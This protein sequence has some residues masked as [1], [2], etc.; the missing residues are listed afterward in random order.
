MRAFAVIALLL[1]FPACGGGKGS[2]SS[3]GLSPSVALVNN[4][5]LLSWNASAGLADGYLIEQSTDNATWTQIQSVTETS[6]Y[7]DGLS[8]GTRYYFRVRS[9]NSA[10]N[11]PYSGSTSITL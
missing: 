9:F 8:V 2:N 3:G 10:G 6:T 1:L 4:R 7:V 5:A 11:S